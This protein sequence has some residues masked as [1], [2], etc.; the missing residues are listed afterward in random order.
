LVSPEYA[1]RKHQVPEPV[2][3]KAADVAIPPVTGT[4][5][6]TWLPPVAQPLAPGSGPHAKKLTVPVGVTPV[7]PVTVAL[8]V[9]VLPSVMLDVVGVVVVVELAAFTVKHSV[10][11]PSEDGE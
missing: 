6:P 7:T 8:S 5:L 4:A 9:F 11:L 1:A 3:R 10:L 2:G